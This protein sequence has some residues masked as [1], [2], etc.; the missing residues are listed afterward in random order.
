VSND[1]LWVV[2]PDTLWVAE[3]HVLSLSDYLE[4]LAA[5]CES[6]SRVI[7]NVEVPDRDPWA[8]LDWSSVKGLGASVD[9]CGL[10]ALRLVRALRH[11]ASDTALAERARVAFFEA[12]RDSFVA[13]VVVGVTGP[14]PLGPRDSW[15]FGA[16]A[17]SLLGAGHAVGPLG[18]S[19]VPGTFAQVPRALTLEERIRRIPGPSQPIRIERYST[20]SG[21]VE[22]EVFI[23]GTSDWAVG[24]SDNPFDLESNL[25]LVAGIP[26]ASYIAVEMALRRAGV[27]PGDRV[28]F[29][30]H[31]QGGLIAARM[32]E[33]GRY[34]TT[35]LLTAGA[36]VGVAPI[37][38][39]YPALALS[40]SDD[41]VP[42]LGGAPELT[43]SIGLERHSGSDH[44][45][46]GRAHSLEAYAE[47]ARIADS[48]P[49]RS[50]F[51]QWAR[52]PSMTR[53]EFYRAT[54]VDVG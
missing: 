41:L 42:T 48:S 8:G 33:S 27:K 11:Y 45:D 26:A 23:S 25:A 1:G 34:T 2:G 19:R 47:T 29:V 49:A 3:D 44:G 35:G 37:R 14:G 9:A 17:E 39:S 12:P 31:S 38:G 46:L 15:G 6:I 21:G 50:R 28:S 32:A 36:P 22:T 20:G 51:G 53:P 18:V 30:G 4:T 43:R 16:A 54:R 40:H 13:T 5:R 52:E 24:T 10:S 7:A